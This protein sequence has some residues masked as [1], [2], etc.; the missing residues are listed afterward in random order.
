MEYRKLIS[1][2]KNSYVVSLPKTWV[3]QNKL[4][5]G[6]LISLE[7]K[8]GSIFLSAKNGEEIEEKSCVINIDGK[9]LNQLKRE[10]NAAYIENNRE[11]VFLGKEIKTRSSELLEIIRDL[12][13]LEVL[14]LDSSRIVT[15]D[16]LDMNKVSV[17]ELLKKVDIVVRSMLK[18]CAQ[19]FT[20]DVSD[21][22]NLRDKDVN[23]LSFLIYRTIRYGMRNQ[24]RFLKIF[25]LSAV[26]LLNCYWMTFHLE[27][28]ADEAKRISRVMKV[29]KLS[30]VQQKNFMGLFKD[31]CTYYEDVMKAYYLN[32]REKALELSNRKRELIDK[33]NLF[34]EEIQNV[35]EASY[36]TDRF[37]K[38]LGTVHELDRL[39]Y[40]Y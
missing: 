30:S 21:N 10:L 1:F 39:I 27:A 13:A 19:T 36:M 23:R 28:A 24:S 34:Y 38:L 2:G 37:R 11:I 5:K 16:F 26:D 12:I 4:K 14:E 22:I 25:N 18:D 15:K 9:V 8:P 35:K 7:E 31:C 33:V 40:Q 3:K 6:D 32:N 17:V 29:I 20:E